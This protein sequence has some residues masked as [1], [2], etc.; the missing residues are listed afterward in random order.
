MRTGYP[1]DTDISVQTVRLKFALSHYT[2]DF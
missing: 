1:I 2:A